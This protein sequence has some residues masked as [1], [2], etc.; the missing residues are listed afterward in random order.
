M[1]S[2]IISPSAAMPRNADND[3]AGTISPTDAGAVMLIVRRTIAA[4]AEELFAAWTTPAQLLR[5]W[6]PAP[7]VCTEAAIDLRVGGSYRLANRFPDG[8]VTWI[9]GVFERIERPHALV[10]SWRIEPA[11]MAL[12]RVHVRFVPQGDATEI[13]IVHE[14]IADAATREQHRKGWEG[15]LDRLAQ[16]DFRFGR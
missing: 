11:P 9:S 2:K 14:R 1:R 16:L 4:S 13:V 8:S 7:V 15:C 5:W 10:Y 6:G 3:T 12:E